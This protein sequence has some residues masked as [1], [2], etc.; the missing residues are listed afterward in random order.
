MIDPDQ[1]TSESA[2]DLIG[3]SIVPGGKINSSNTI[4][5][6]LANNGR[7]IIGTYLADLADIDHH[8]IHTDFA[9]DWRPLH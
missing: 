1:T 7:D 5:P 8:L 4:L 9:D 3:Y 2:K 6:I